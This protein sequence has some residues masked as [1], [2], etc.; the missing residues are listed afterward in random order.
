M[1]S[2]PRRCLVRRF[3][4]FSLLLAALIMPAAA[5][6]AHENITIDGDLTD[7]ISAVNNNLGP[8]N[9]GFVVSDPLGDTYTGPCAYVNGYDLRQSYILVDFK[10]AMGNVTPDNMILYAGWDMEGL[11]GDVDGDGNPNTFSIGSPGGSTGCAL[12]DEAGIGPNESYN[13]LLDLDCTGGVDDVRIQ[14]KNGTVSRIVNAVVTPLPSATFAFAGDKLELK[15]PNYKALLM[16][17]P[18]TTDLCDA[19]MRLTANA[20]FDGP[21]EDFS[22][23]SQLELL[24]SVAVTKTPGEQAICAG[25]PV[26]WTITV[27]ND[28][29]CRLDDITIEDTLG[30]GLTY[31]NA[32]MPPS[33]VKGPIIRWEFPGIGLMPGQT[34]VINLTASTPPECASG[35]LSNDVTVEAIHLNPCLAPGTPAPT[36]SDKASAS[37]TCRDL[38]PCDIAGDQNTCVGRSETYTTSI[39]A[40]YTTLWS[41]T[42]TP[43]GI[44]N[45]VGDPAGPSITV[46]FTGA[47][48]CT[49]SLSVTD[50][51]NPEICTKT[52]TYLVTVN[53]P[54]P[55][56]I[57]GD[58]HTCFPMSEVYTTNIGPNYTKSWSVTSV[59][60]GIA[61]ING[62]ANGDQ[63]TVDYTGAGT[64]TVHLNVT[65]PNDPTDCFSVCEMGV[66][67]DAMPPCDISG[68]LSLCLKDPGPTQETYT[69]TV[70]AQYDRVWSI[71]STPPGI[72]SFVGGN[73][74]GSVTVNYTGLGDVTVKLLV[75]DPADPTDCHHECDVTVAVMPPPPCDIAGDDHTC[76]PMSETYTTTV[77][78]EFNRTWSVMS[79]PPGIASINGPANGSSVQID[80][81]GAGTVTVKLGVFDPEDAT[82][83]VSMCEKVV[84]VDAMPPCDISGDLHTCFP[85]SETYTTTVGAQ[86]DRTWSVTSVPPGIAAINGSNTGGSVTVD[87]TGAGTVTVH[88]VV[89]DPADPT[90]CHHECTVEVDVDAMPP[91]D[92][93][94]DLAICLDAAGA[95][96]GVYTTTVGA[97]YTRVWSIES[98]PP[99][100]ASFNGGNTGGSVT[101]DY[102]GEGSVSLKLTVTDPADPEDCHHECSQ[103]I[104]VTPAPPCNI[105]GDD[106]TCFP[107]SET[108]TTNV[109]AQYTRQ[110]SVSSVPPGIASINGPSTGGSVLIDFT[111]EGTVTVKLS[112]FDPSDP[113]DCM[114]MCTK[115]VDVDAMPPCD[116]SGDLH[117]C[118]PMSE[119]YSTTVTAA[120]NRA[121]SVSSVPPGIASIN[122][123]AN[124]SSITVDY[125]GAGTV[126]VHLLVTDPADPTDCHHECTVEVD[127]DAM[128]PCDISGDLSTCIKVP[129]PTQ[130]TYTTTAGAQYNR[131]WSIESNPPGI[132]SFVGGVNTGGSVTLDYTGVG[133][134]TLKLAVTDPADPADCHHECQVDID[135]LPTPPCDIAGDDHTCFPMSEVYTTTVGAEYSRQ[136]TVMSNPP[137][138]ASINGSATGGSVTVDFTGEGQVTV[139]LGVFDPAD[140]TDC[141]SMCEKVVDVDA[142]PPCDI[143]GDL[144]TCFPMSETYTTTVTSAYNRAW[145]VSSVPAGIASI[146]GP[147]DGGS[148]T[149]NYTGAGTVTIKLVVTDPADPTD[150]V[151]ECT[152]TV[153]VD[154]Q[155]PCDISGDL[156]TCLRV[157][158]PTQETYTTTVGAE[159]SR[160]WS[161]ESVPAGIASFVGGVNTGGS[162]TLDYTATGTVTL[163]LTVTDPAD[164]E[165]CVHVCEQTI[166]VMPT[167]PCDITGDDHTCFPMSETYSTTVGAGY[168]KAWTVMSVPPGIAAISGPA[169]GSSVTVNFTGAGTVTVKLGVFDPND[170]TDCLSMCEK[171]V[172]VDPG[173]P[174]DITG[175]LHTCFP[176]TETY[177]TTVG[178][179]YARQWSVSSVP[180]G[181]ASI[182][183]S[184]T[185]G[186]VSIHYTGAGTVT[187]KLV[188]TDPADPIDCVHECTQTVTVE[189]QPS[190]NITGPGTICADST[191][192]FSA[193]GGAGLTLSWSATSNPPGI[194]M[195]AGGQVGNMV[196]LN[197]SGPGTVTLTLNVSFTNDPDDCHSTCMTTLTVEDCIPEPELCWM[198]GGGC[199]DEPVKKS[200]K[201]SSF[202][203]NI[204]A[205]PQSGTWEHIQRDG[206]NNILFNFHSWDAMVDSCWHDGGDGPCSPRT[207]VNNIAWSGTGKYSIGNGSREYAGTFTAHVADH[208]EPGSHNGPC[209]STDFYEITVFDTNGKVVFHAG[210]FLSCGNMQLH[211][212]NG[213]QGQA[214]EDWRTLV[215][216]PEGWFNESQLLATRPYPNPVT[217]GAT[218]ISWSIPSGTETS[219]VGITVFDVAGRVIR[220]FDL[221]EQPS[222][223]H[224]VD[225]DLR[226]ENGTDVPSGIYFYR[227]AVGSEAITSKLMVVRQ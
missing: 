69:T 197:F 173:P 113:E 6:A 213:N 128:P 89:T 105:D 47:G 76:F 116:I 135:I 79:V 43:P 131:V 96:Q 33:M 118:F 152:A 142:M 177:T 186:S 160:V 147:A 223:D 201:K 188:V 4:T 215:D 40:P 36:A 182:N 38:P 24:P 44:C 58:D 204:H 81:T 146:V 181:I 1:L 157:P 174:C 211:P 100:I 7:L 84:D 66:D 75:T 222:G 214:P 172:D 110:W 111:G 74:G 149:V 178:A 28:G 170:P 34:K 203:G 176:A 41:V 67:V 217:S 114:S 85:M 156:S 2:A 91:C 64:V 9:G 18:I 70:G 109:G 90:D 82:D 221:G 124:G 83:C 163:K 56:N 141:L 202:G 71:E 93:A 94:G 29:L 107:M 62:A 72:A 92:I 192:T 21:G 189:A 136:W 207:D 171:V 168:T 227:L 101:I 185:G 78:S 51:L 13:L 60:A 122:G 119:T 200:H 216:W 212:L 77:G 167:P 148:V 55:C 87:Y 52:C 130:E 88:L 153:D 115:I 37:V 144:H 158:G 48:V 151:H 191:A 17:L 27:T 106:H 208:G 155:P 209:G 20:E 138:I 8:S 99:G 32:D 132:A 10:D 164:A 57:E 103:T 195:F 125:T 150:C 46:N 187:V 19:R 59:P 12:S 95:A 205:P 123:P 61:A 31:A 39:G 97:Q 184:S 162:V 225:W 50:P 165:D 108:Y 219:R 15:I 65:D 73:T 86:Y 63:V 11:V 199:L 210:D 134:V 143:S 224:S 14:I 206:G 23:P 218:S 220:T 154:A 35:T 16:D 127:V 140:P 112:V 161:I 45:T 30:E 183:G 49:V 26:S 226:D 22:G 166:T 159:F 193:T 117:T 169:N 137:G 5:R 126:T 120:Y 198:T 42:S 68:D 3:L 129:G 145:S 179:E 104:E 196:H 175:D 190:C 180:P 53:P 121:W 139:K 133:D 80:Y 194:F 98:T 102:T 54:P 25:E